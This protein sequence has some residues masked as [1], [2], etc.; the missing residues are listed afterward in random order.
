[1][2]EHVNS[3]ILCCSRSLYALKTLKAHGLPSAEVQE[4]FRATV[5]NSLLYASPAWWGLASAADIARI[6]SY[7]KRAIKF[8]YCSSQLPTLQTLVNNADSTLFKQI[9]SDKFHIL[10][11]LLPHLKPRHHNLRPRSHPYVIPDRSTAL[12]D[13]TFLT[14]TVCYTSKILQVL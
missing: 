1:M 5:L 14:R 7:L 2:S 4:V 6:N 9:S 10:H 3:K 12:L 11:P 13:K 8:G